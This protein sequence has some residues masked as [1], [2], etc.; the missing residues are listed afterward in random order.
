[1]AQVAPHA[2]TP[3]AHLPFISGVSLLIHVV[4][5]IAIVSVPLL[6]YDVLPAPEEAVRAFFVESSP[7]APLP[8]PPPPQ[9]AAG[10]G[11]QAKAPAAPTSPEASSSLS[12]AAT[13]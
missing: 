4:P 3:P 12:S 13:Q 10:A 5:V 2:S 7:A 1:M 6:T 8:P 11:S 9:T